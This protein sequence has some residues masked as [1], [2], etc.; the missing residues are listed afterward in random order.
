MDEATAKS[1]DETAEPDLQSLEERLVPDDGEPG[2]SMIHVFI[3]PEPR[4]KP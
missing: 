1:Y 3:K 2:E 4:K